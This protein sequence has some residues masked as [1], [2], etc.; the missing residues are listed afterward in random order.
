[1][2][3]EDFVTKDEIK[4]MEGDLHKLIEDMDVTKLNTA[5]SCDKHVGIIFIFRY[6]YIYISVMYDILFIYPSYLLINI[7]L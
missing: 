2:I 3:M 5:F 4:S 1:M 6:M 7:Y